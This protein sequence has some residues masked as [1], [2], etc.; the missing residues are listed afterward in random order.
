[1]AAL[2]RNAIM[3]ATDIPV[4]VIPVPEWNGEVYV[5]RQSIRERDALIHMSRGFM[6]IKPPKKEGDK[7]EITMKKGPEAEEAYVKYRLFTVGFALCDENGDRL[8]ND[9]EIEKTLGK[10]ST[11]AIERIFNELG[12]A[13]NDETK[14]N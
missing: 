12:N 6:D 8:F 1:M 13:F 11:E 9:D 7:P 14:A 2:D 5:K 4:R 3:G 10:K